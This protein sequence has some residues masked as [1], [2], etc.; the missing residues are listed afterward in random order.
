MILPLIFL[1]LLP[2]MLTVIWL[3]FYRI[4]GKNC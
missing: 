1:L 4:A 2:S 3:S